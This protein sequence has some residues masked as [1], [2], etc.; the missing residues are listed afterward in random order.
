[1]RTPFVAVATVAALVLAA[2]ATAGISRSLGV[3][4]WGNPG[5]CYYGANSKCWVYSHAADQNRTSCQVVDLDYD[6]GHSGPNSYTRSAATDIANIA[7]NE[8]YQWA[9]GCYDNNDRDPTP[10]AYPRETKSTLGEGPDCSG[11]V[12]RVWRESNRAYPGD[13]SFWFWQRSTYDHGPYDTT[14]FKYS[15]PGNGAP[16]VRY[17][18]SSIIMMDALAS[19]THIALEQ[20]RIDSGSD[21][22]WEA[23]GEAYGTNEWIESYRSQSKFSGVRRLAWG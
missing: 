23:L 11:L 22:V 12:W 20:F 9:G 18:K 21:F 16:H 2:G 3:P 1:M 7:V 10:N 4:G 5:G 8:G 19:D 13:N 6:P 14:A 15:T 17:D